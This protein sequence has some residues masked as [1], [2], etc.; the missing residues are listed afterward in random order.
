MNQLLESNYSDSRFGTSRPLL[1]SHTHL[2]SPSSPL[3]LSL[4]LSCHPAQDQDTGVHYKRSEASLGRTAV[5]FRPRL[6]HRWG[7]YRRE[8]KDLLSYCWV[9][10]V[11]TWSTSLTPR[12]LVAMVTSLSDKSTNWKRW[13]DYISDCKCHSLSLSLSLTRLQGEGTKLTHI[14]SH[15]TSFLLQFCPCNTM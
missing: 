10:F 2:P 7:E 1:L 9:T 6:L 15:C 11:R 12:L 4:S 5:I 13:D 3:S 8:G 14:V